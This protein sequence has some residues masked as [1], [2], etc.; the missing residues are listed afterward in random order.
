MRSQ[1][2]KNLISL[3]KNITRR[4]KQTLEEIAENLSHPQQS[5]APVPIPIPVRSGRNVNRLNKQFARY[6]S[7]SNN[8]ASGHYKFRAFQF[9]NMKYSNSGK[10]GR[11]IQN[12]SNWIRFNIQ[13]SN[14]NQY[15]SLRTFHKSFLYNN[16]SQRY[17]SQFGNK[18]AN[19]NFFRH[20]NSGSPIKN[21]NLNIR[22]FMNSKKFDT[23]DHSMYKQDV[24]LHQKPQ[25]KSNI[26]LNVSLTPKFSEL[27]L[28]MAR[29]VSSAG[30]EETSHNTQVSNGCYVDFPMSS[31]FSIPSMTILNNEI[32]DELMLD[33]KILESRIAELKLDLQGLFELGEL[34]MKYLHDQNILRVYFANCDKA[35]L[36]GLLRE[37]NIKNGI[38]YEEAVEGC[39]STSANVSEADIL[40]SYYGS[41]SSHGSTTE[42][43]D[44]I[45]SD[46]SHHPLSSDNIIRIES[47]DQSQNSQHV[48]FSEEDICWV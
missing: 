2:M 26:R 47:G 24:V 27:T 32:L 1:T 4:I 11:I 46:S 25:V 29:T 20:P 10:L 33:L 5:P 14:F 21:L 18:M 31:K 12:N 23:S 15:R 7:T 43:D 22:A 13:N 3:K 30:C 37:K 42:Y 8:F 48:S 44:D 9:L 28:L 17:Q 41:S 6:Y 35:R 19:M 45:L 38:I 40:S 16:F 34:P 39:S 36:E